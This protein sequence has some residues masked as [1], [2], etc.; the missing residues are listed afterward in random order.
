[1]AKMSRDRGV[2][3][4]ARHGMVAVG[5][6]NGEKGCLEWIRCLSRSVLTRGTLPFFIALGYAL[7]ASVHFAMMEL[8]T[9]M[10]RHSP[11]RL[12]SRPTLR[13]AL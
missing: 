4:M 1:M 10:K 6:M 8:R 7:F 12:H 2:S 5:A 9:E 13:G 11:P 3:G